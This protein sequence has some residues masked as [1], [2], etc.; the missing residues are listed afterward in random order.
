MKILVVRYRFIGDMV[1]MIPFLRNLRYKYPNAQIDMLVAPNSGEVISNCP[2]V[3][4][5]IFFDTTRKHKYENGVGKQKSFLHYV[6]LLRKEKYNKTYVLKRSLSSAVLVFL[7][8]IPERIGFNT[9]HRG[10]F[11]TKKVKYDTNKHESICALDLLEADNIQIKDTFLENWTDPKS[12]YKV[13]K[14]FEFYNI[15]QNQKK[16]IVH[17]AAS[18]PYKTWNIDYFAQIIEYLSN[19]KN[20]QVFFLGAKIDKSIYENIKY[21]SV[22]KI[23][24]INLCGELTIQESLAFI[25]ATDLLIGNDSGNLHMASSVNTPVIG[26]YGPMP[27]E[28]W[29]ALGDKNILFKSEV[30]CAPCSLKKK[31]K[32]NKA[33]LNSISPSLIKQ[34]V[35]KFF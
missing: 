3:N 33:C 30:S 21:N 8:G 20:A 22:L 14:I 4:N 5:F 12:D 18:N 6:K 28:K 19:E 23:K 1:L 32:N 34:A 27:F 15:L 10:I 9:E 25:K 24:P 29:K 17:A 2:Y 7:A 31:C 11:L 35:D 13:N 16:V 26:I